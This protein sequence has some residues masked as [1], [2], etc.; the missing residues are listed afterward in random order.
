MLMLLIDAAVLMILLKTINDDDDVG[1]G[2]AI[3]TALITSIGTGLL[4]YGLVAA[5]GPAGVFVAA[6]IAATLL[7]IAVAAFFGVEI[8]RA[9]LIAVIFITVHIAASLGL[10]AM[11]A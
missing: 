3:V 9:M 2:T 8:K 5:M 11:M 6:M 4:A 10:H 1:L 7:G